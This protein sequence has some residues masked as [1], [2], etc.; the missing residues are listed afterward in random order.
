[1]L[2][3]KCCICGT[4]ISN[5]NNSWSCTATHILSH[6]IGTPQDIAAAAALASECEA[7]GE[8]FPLHKL[9]TPLAAKKELA[10]DVGPM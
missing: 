2:K 5:H 3:T 4:L 8:P 9:P 6:N 10:S 7:N 1:M